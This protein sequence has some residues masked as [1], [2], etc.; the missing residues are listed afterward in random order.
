MPALSVSEAFAELPDPR[1]ERTRL[2]RLHD[3]L[4]I[5]L[6]AMLCGA[7][8]WD[9]FVEFA[10]AKRE[11][12]TARLSL[13]NGIPC[14]DTFRRVFARLDPEAF[15]AGFLR[16]TQAI[17]ADMETGL[18]VVAVDGKTLRHSFDTGAA[19]KAV[20]M[21]S[22]WASAQRLVLAQTKVDDTSNEITAVPALLSLLD[23][24]G[25]IVT[26]DAMSCQK[27]I[28][29]QIV[30]QGGDYVLALKGNQ[31]HLANDV[32]ALFAHSAAKRW[33]ECPHSVHTA[34]E[35]EHG[36]LE[37]RT[38]RVIALADLEGTWDDIAAEWT[39][40]AC[41]VE[42]DSKRQVGQHLSDERRYYLS[43]LRKSAKTHLKIIRR[44][45]EI[46]NSVHWVL[47]VVMHEDACRIRKDNA[48]QNMA[49]LRHLALNLIRQETTH[50]RG[51]KAKIKRAGWDNDYLARLIQI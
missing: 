18:R 27:V 26:A 33:E 10:H 6:C 36:R 9:D 45:W 37:T 4:V 24:A 21:V 41:L 39:G 12:L 20:H 31:E 42:I 22:A 5:A 51:V 48:P 50:K 16:W 8:G 17:A 2:H 46:E 32:A 34:V 49:T 35:A 19:Q 40:L 15:G 29:A 43:S 13:Q 38:C 7:E 47:D 28:A 30:E 23:L 25:C 3:I 14:A 11:W 1:V 44:H